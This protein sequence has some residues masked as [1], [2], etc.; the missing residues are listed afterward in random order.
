MHTPASGSV[1]DLR[2]EEKGCTGHP[3]FRLN[4]VLKEGRERMTLLVD[5]EK[6]P[7]SVIKVIASKHGYRIAGY[8]ERDEGVVVELV[9]KG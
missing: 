6:L 5:P 8:S 7:L 2:R 1:I 9:K 3:V 4:V